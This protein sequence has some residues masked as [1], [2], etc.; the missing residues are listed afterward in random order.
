MKYLIQFSI[1]AGISFLGELL[2]HIIPL[3]IP[4]SIYGLALLM[5]LLVVKIIPY[6]AVKETGHFL[7]DIM[8]IMFLP[9]AVGLMVSFSVLKAVLLPYAVITIVTT[10]L[11]M[12]IAGRTTQTIIRKD[13]KA[14]E[15][16]ESCT[17]S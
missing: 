5:I 10:F 4:A 1:I 8:P 11:V 15:E 17:N 3:P 14:K 9:A 2:H 12:L 13:K 6:S 16:K 7:I